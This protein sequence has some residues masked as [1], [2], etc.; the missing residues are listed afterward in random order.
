LEHLEGAKELRK[1]FWGQQEIER[2]EEDHKARKG[3]I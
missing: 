3:N 2:D 1:R